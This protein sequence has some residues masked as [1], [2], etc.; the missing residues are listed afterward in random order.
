MKKALVCAA[1]MLLAP[2]SSARMVH[3]IKISGIIDPGVGSYV[4]S[5]IE[6]AEEADSQ[7]LVIELNTPGG[8]L[9]T[10]KEMV[11]EFLDSD[12]P[13]VVYVS[14]SGAS[15]T[16]AGMMITVAAHVAV[17]APGT[18][19]GA[20]HP[21]L[22]PFGVKYEP[23]PEGDVMMEKATKDTAGWIRSICEVRGR[24][25]D[26][27]EK[28]V[29]ESE[30]ITAIEAVKQNVVDGMA[31]DFEALVNEFLHGR[32]VILKGGDTVRL[33]T[34]K[35]AVARP[36]M[37]TPQK[38]QHYI[39]NPNL[40]LIL[41]LLGGLGI[42]LEFKNPGMIF[43]GVVGAG[44]VLVALVAPSLP[45]NYIGLL[46]ILLA[47]VFLVAEVFVTSYGVLTVA[48]VAALVAGSLMLFD[49]EG[50]TN[51]TPSWYVIGAIVTFVV[52][53]VLVFGGAVLAAHRQKVTT[54]YD[55]LIGEIAR[56][57]TE[58]GPEGGKIFVHGE[59]W[60]AVSESPVA[61][62]EKVV[63]KS[64]KGLE[65]KVERYFPGP[66]PEKSGQDGEQPAT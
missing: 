65:C 31:D 43:P 10:T 17:M 27:A 21:V 24:N 35:A 47:F 53:V 19:I 18:N 16:S 58:V 60:N 64:V 6:A 52:V 54:G 49:T 30:S 59:F 32:V 56:A 7:A 14:P 12:V 33:D 40:I 63:I 1:L 38:L 37:T 36:E 3:A 45:V 42:A 66:G 34:E 50:V 46:L 55:E 48:G 8:I 28:A 61:K 41:L 26:W 11:Q 25:A 5:S 23:V 57:E 39:N 22:M 62:G 4:K 2:A 29:T 13:V 15:A 20:A 9:A 44:C 51:V